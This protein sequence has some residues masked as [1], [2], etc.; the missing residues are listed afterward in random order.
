MKKKMISI[1]IVSVLVL[2]TAIVAFAGGSGSYS[3]TY[4]MTGGV[5]SRQM[6]VGTNPS[7]TAKL[8]PTQS[9]PTNLTVYLEKKTS[10]GWSSLISKDVSSSSNSTTTFT[11]NNSGIYRFY[12]RNWSGQ[13]AKGNVDISW[14]W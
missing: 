10:T 7:F 12:F 14:K 6:D 11:N 4:S 2:S 1:M 13:L 8:K 5:Y 9:V 3:S